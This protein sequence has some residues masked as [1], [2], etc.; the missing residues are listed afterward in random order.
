MDNDGD[1]FADHPADAGCASL[2]DPS[3]KSPDL[4]CDDGLDNDGD[5]L[6]D[7]PADRGCWGIRDRTETPPPAGFLDFTGNLTIEVKYNE[8]H[9]GWMGGGCSSSE[10]VLGTSVVPGSGIAGVNGAGAPGH[11]TALDLAGGEFAT[12]SQVVDVMD[13]DI[14]PIS[15]LQFTANN[16][17]GAF[18][19][20]GGD[21]FGGVM[22]LDGI[23]KLCLFGECPTAAGNIDLPLSVVGKGGTAFAAGAGLSLTVKGAPWTTGTAAIRTVDGG[24]DT[25][26]GGVSP[27]SHT[28]ETGGTVNLVTPIFISTNVS[29]WPVL[30]TFGVLDLHFTP[31]PGALLLAGAAVASLVALGIA[32]SRRGS[33]R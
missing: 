22:P 16:G 10:G 24:T 4:V 9:C 23:M 25:V 29:Y 3:E 17:A 26:M 19:G 12:A 11:L 33:P 8:W 18:A 28:G 2:I 1:T 31:E 13:P 32:R 6:V 15:G 7:Y 21:S 20:A 30:P 5:E 27:L 14:A